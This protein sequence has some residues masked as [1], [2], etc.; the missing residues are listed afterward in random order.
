VVVKSLRCRLSRGKRIGRNG[1]ILETTP[2]KNDFSTAAHGI[3]AKEN[4]IPGE[5][6]NS[7]VDLLT[8]EWTGIRPKNIENQ[9]VRTP[10]NF[11]SASFSMPA[12]SMPAFPLVL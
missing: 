12:F 4:L 3:D 5:L 1:L 10:E 2:V 6:W 8:C 7:R 9:I 11:H